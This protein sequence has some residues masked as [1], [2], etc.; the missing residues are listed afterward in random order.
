MQKLILSFII[1]LFGTVSVSSDCITLID[2][3]G[4]CGLFILDTTGC[5][6]VEKLCCG[7]S[8]R[9]DKKRIEKIIIKGDTVYYGQ[10]KD[11]KELKKTSQLLYTSQGADSI[12]C[13]LNNGKIK[14]ETVLKNLLKEIDD[15][16]EDVDSIQSKYRNDIEAL[17]GKIADIPCLKLNHIGFVHSKNNNF[18]VENVDCC[19]KLNVVRSKILVRIKS[20]ELIDNYKEVYAKSKLLEQLKDRTLKH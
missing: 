9:I 11:C 12:C 15:P 10:K 6:V 7:D 14:L 4:S 2:G 16:W 13:C 18:T 8:I 19:L 1:L 5:F 3:T 17:N 20:F